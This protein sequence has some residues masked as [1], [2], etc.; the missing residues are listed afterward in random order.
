MC[1]YVCIWI[2]TGI[3]GKDELADAVLGGASDYISDIITAFAKVFYASDEEKVSICR[4]FIG[5]GKKDKVSR[6]HKQHSSI[7]TM[8]LSYTWKIKHCCAPWS[9]SS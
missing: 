3:A 1:M 6:F 9:T 8:V 7:I 5:E 2:H 4:D